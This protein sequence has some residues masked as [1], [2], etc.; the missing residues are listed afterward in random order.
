[1]QYKRVFTE[2]FDQK[3]NDTLVGICRKHTSRTYTVKYMCSCQFKLKKMDT[4]FISTTE[5]INKLC[6]LDTVHNLL[7]L[8]Y[9]IF[10]LLL[11]T[12]IQVILNK[13]MRLSANYLK[14]RPN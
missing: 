5:F 8:N 2:L 6:L 11:L 7:V 1:M 4:V 9:I 13:L 14:S 3:F 10:I 12:V